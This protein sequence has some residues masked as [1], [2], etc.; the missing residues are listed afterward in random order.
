M[1][2]LNKQKQWVRASLYWV[3]TAFFTLLAGCGD[4]D[5]LEPI[6][7]QDDGM[8]TSEYV[9]ELRARPSKICDCPPDVRVFYSSQAEPDCSWVC[10]RITGPKSRLQYGDDEIDDLVD[11]FE[12]I[13]RSKPD[14]DDQ[15]R[16]RECYTVCPD[17]SV[18]GPHPCSETAAC[19]EE[20][21][22]YIDVSAGGSSTL[23]TRR[24]GQDPED[25]TPKRSS[26]Y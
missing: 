7:P 26:K 16:V 11:R 25:S 20:K 2:F 21:D 22:K 14:D 8:Q 24:V 13:P 12:N 6:E 17:W 19:L 3:V 9:G 23:D 18:I 10:G 5:H 4:F 1:S 15:A